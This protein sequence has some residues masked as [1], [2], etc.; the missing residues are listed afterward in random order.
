ME[1]P[2]AFDPTIVFG[3]ATNHSNIDPSLQ[4]T[5]Y[6]QTIASTS[7]PGS[8]SQTLFGGTG[9]TVSRALPLRERYI[10]SFYENFYTAH[11]FIPPKEILLILAQKISLEPLFAAIRW[12]GSLF[13][14]RDSSHSLLTDASHEIDSAPLRN[15]FLV[16]AMLL[17]IIGLDGN[18]Q[19][20]KARQLMADARDISIQIKVNTDPFAVTNGQGIPI[21]EESWRRTWWELY[22]VDALMSGVHQTNTFVLYDLPTDVGLPCEESQYLTGVSLVIKPG[23]HYM[24]TRSS[25]YLP[26]FTHAIRKPWDCLIQGRFR[27]TPIGSNVPASWVRFKQC[28]QR[29]TMS[30]GCLL[31]GCSAY[32]L[33]NT[34]LIAMAI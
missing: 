25:K 14:D 30:P 1:F 26:L 8:S 3:S 19:E 29:S 10:D 23:K 21:L 7:L 16:Q 24:F 4:I 18:R 13:I 12:I 32:L 11:P 33:Q 5:T 6:S 20:K 31:T 17:V 22:V 28:H 2:S 34:T 9:S 15:G 27:R